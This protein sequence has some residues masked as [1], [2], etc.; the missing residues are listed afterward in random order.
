MVRDLGLLLTFFSAD[1]M[2]GVVLSKT[3]FMGLLSGLCLRK[4]EKVSD[5]DEKSENSP[6]FN[7]LLVTLLSG[8]ITTLTKLSLKTSS[9]IRLYLGAGVDT[10]GSDKLTVIESSLSKSSAWGISSR[11]P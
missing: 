6:E 5:V 11:S 2:F 10:M 7:M 8:D 3:T 4:G 1:L 9:D